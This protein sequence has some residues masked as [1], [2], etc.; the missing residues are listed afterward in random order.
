VDVDMVGTY[1]LWLVILSIVVAVI[2]SHVALDLTA[3]LDTV[4]A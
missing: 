1:D 4:G 2:A 3:T